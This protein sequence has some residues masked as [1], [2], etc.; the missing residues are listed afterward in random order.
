MRKHAEEHG[1]DFIQTVSD[2]LPQEDADNM[3]FGAIDHFSYVFI[4][5]DSTTNNY[6]KVFTKEENCTISDQ[7][8]CG[9]VKRALQNLEN[10][11]SDPKNKV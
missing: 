9:G 5:P 7:E 1:N 8:L 6:S 10:F 11:M 2:S 4:N 3:L